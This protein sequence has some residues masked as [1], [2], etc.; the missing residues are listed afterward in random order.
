MEHINLIE[1]QL[2][3]LKLAGI[4]SSLSRRIVEASE[5]SLS[6]TEFLNLVLQ[7]E[8]TNRKNARIERLQRSAGFRSQ[9]SCE[10]IDFAFPRGLSKKAILDVASGTY[11]D[12]G[13]NILILGP[14]GV[15]KTH[16]ATA[17]GNTACRNG[18]SVLFLRMNTL[19]ERTAL[20]RAQGNWL[21]YLRKLAAPEVLI[22][23]DFGIK[24]LTPQQFQDLYDVIDERGE[25]KSI[26]ITSQVPVDNWSEV[27][28]DPVVCE[29]ISDRIVHKSQV[30]QMKGESYRKNRKNNLTQTDPL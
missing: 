18:R 2:I 14:T 9:A 3:D 22:L 4:R 11:I 25:N 26:I 19:I 13:R 23:D 16:I 27:I 24:P 29:A 20:A 10:G 1:S 5:A 7:D 12:D 6:H 30:I 17:I 15:G 21:N 28:A 8:I